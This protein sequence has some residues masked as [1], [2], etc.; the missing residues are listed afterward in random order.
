MLGYV[1]LKHVTCF[2]GRQHNTPTKALSGAQQDKAQ[3]AQEK[4]MTHTRLCTHMLGM[5][6]PLT[7]HMQELQV[8]T[9]FEAQVSDPDVNKLELACSL[10]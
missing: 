5:S 2:H 10:Q 4:R 9:L 6:S 7:N 3:P 8:K 1:S